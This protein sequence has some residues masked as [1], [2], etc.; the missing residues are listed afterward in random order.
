MTLTDTNKFIK[1]IV[2]LNNKINNN[3]YINKILKKDKNHFLFYLLSIN[4]IN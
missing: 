4:D 3:N 2:I 1:K